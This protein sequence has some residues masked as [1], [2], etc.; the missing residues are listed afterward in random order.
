MKA[1][2]RLSRL[3]LILAAV[4]LPTTGRAHCDTLQG[5]V[6]AEARAALA[7]GDVTPVLKWVKS[8][9]EAEVR[10]A[11]QRTLAVRKQSNEAGELADQWFFETLVR[12]HRAGEGAP[13]TGLKAGPTDEPGIAAA[14]H[15][16][17]TGKVEEVLAETA[18][19]LEAAVHAKFEHVRAL[20]LH[21]ADSVAAGREFVEAYVEYVH[22][23][24]HLATV[25]AGKTAADAPA[26]HIE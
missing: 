12:V 23:I 3:S 14:D 1:T 9:D 16:L 13:Y 4:L 20:Q 18:R 17:G 8:A 22:F 19:P 21:A 2:T 10:A 7:K 6:V 5:P 11:F 26:P 25:A 24:E 15:A